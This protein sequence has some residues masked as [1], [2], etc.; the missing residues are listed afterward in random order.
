MGEKLTPYFKYVVLASLIAIPIFGHLDTLPIRIWDE[1]RL[2]LNAYAMSNNGNFIVTY[3]EG[4]PD[5]W[6][7]K[8]PLLIWFQVFFIK[9]FGFN[10]LSVRLPS[11]IAAFFTCI[12]L[13]FFSLRHLNNYWFGFIAVLVLITSHGYINTHATRTGDYDALLTLFTTVS[14]LLFFAY[15]ET[16]NYKH[17]YLF[18]LFTAL[19]VL[20]KSVTGLLFLPALFLYSIIQK[21]FIPLI[22][23]KHFYIGLF[24]FLGLVIG[25]YLF[26]EANNAGY[27]A[28]VYE[29][30][31]GGRY[32][33]VIEN[34]HQGFWY[35]YNNFIDFQLTAWYL[36]IP[37]GLITG[38]VVKNKMI[39]RITLFSFLMLLSFFLVISTAG[40]KLEWYDVPMYPFLAII[41]AVFIFY[42]FE[43]LQNLKSLNETLTV[44]VIP[45]I[46]L[47]LIGI[48]PYQKIID[49]TYLPKE[50]SWDEDFYEIGY[51]LKDAIRGR[52]DLN[53]QYLLYDGYNTHNLFYLKILNDKGIKISFKDWENLEPNDIVVAYQPFVKD[54]VEENYDLDK[55]HI[56]GNVVTYEIYGRK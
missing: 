11:A 30:E 42:I 38:L 24:S 35:Y 15:C 19:A 34:H 32:L 25:Y 33:G 29:N 52:Y 46:F 7:T 20:T 21:Q 10:E 49:K 14:G 31:L 37:C 23:S 40:T 2:A 51:F 44:N 8:P 9:L 28:A 26:R 43:L 6:N 48:S 17:L 3:F 47:F 39:N 16:R 4:E 45:F 54:Y 56:V 55:P 13:V 18:F 41:V 53:N 12:A 1:A 22:K 50:Y 5:M 36:L 27:I